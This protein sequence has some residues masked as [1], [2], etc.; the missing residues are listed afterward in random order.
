MFILHIRDDFYCGIYIEKTYTKCNK[1]VHKCI[2]TIL[3]KFSTV[4]I[5]VVCF[6]INSIFGAKF[7]SVF[8]ICIKITEN[9]AALCISIKIGFCTK[10]ERF[11]CVLLF[12]LLNFMLFHC[13]N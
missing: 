4:Y 5:G 1:N 13:F 10:N 3:E 12:S 7:L 8:L 6:D 2:K 9:A 11:L